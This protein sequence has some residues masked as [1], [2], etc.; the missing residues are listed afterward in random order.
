MGSA[1]NPPPGQEHQVAGEFLAVADDPLLVAADTSG[2]ALN[3]SMNMREVDEFSERG[4][5]PPSP[6]K[7]AIVHGRVDLFVPFLPLGCLL[8]GVLR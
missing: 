1:K 7:A 3:A 8:F 4:S 5:G 6:T 2:G